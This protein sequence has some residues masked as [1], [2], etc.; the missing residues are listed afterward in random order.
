[1][2]RCLI[3]LLAFLLLR[4]TSWG[5]TIRVGKGQAVATIRQAHQL[6]NDGDTLWVYPGTYKEKN[7]TIT[8]KLTLLGKD[9]PVLDG[10]H[11]YEIISVKSPGVV[12]RGF[13]LTHSGVSSIEDIA[14]IKIYNVRHVYIADNIFYDTFF[15]IYSQSS[16]NCTFENNKLTGIAV[17][18]QA[19]GNGIHCWK[20]DSLKIIANTVTGHRDGIYFEF[21]TNSVIWRNTSYNNMRYGLHFMFSNNDAYVSNV[22]RNNGAGVSVMYTHNVKMFNNVF[23]ENWGDAAYGIFLKEISDS[24]I[25]GNKFLHNTSGIFME[26]TSRILVEKNVFTG[27]GW[28]LKIQASCLDNVIANNNFKGNTFDIG[29]NGSLVMNKFDHNY[30]DK[31]EGYDLNRDKTGDVPY[32]PVSLYSM[33]V[34]KNPAAMMLFR[35]FM[36]SLL[37]KSEKILPT[38][39]PESLKDNFPRMK[40]LPL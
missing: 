37:D 39:T 28:A 34:E 6:A 27:N 7:I 33:I 19:S 38:L 30:W 16:A 12:I 14:A 36:T 21:V 8:K 25:L 13:K 22:F 1:M 9:Y 4:G 35:S 3:I 10:E 11:K 24:H 18:E 40:P 29:T 5:T 17:T 15:G 2:K 23:E 32:R 31:Y 26:G 20:S